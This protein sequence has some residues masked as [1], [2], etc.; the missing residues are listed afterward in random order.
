MFQLI[1]EKCSIDL[2]KMQDPYVQLKLHKMF[3]LLKLQHTKAN[4]LEYKRRTSDM[5][6]GMSFVKLFV[7]MV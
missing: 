5:H 4:V 1:D 6:E 2:R 7:H 3:Q